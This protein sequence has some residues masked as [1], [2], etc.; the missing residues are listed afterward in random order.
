MV[1]IV[2]SRHSVLDCEHLLLLMHLCILYL[3]KKT[4]HPVLKLRILAR[5]NCS[6]QCF[7]H[8]S[9]LLNLHGIFSFI[10]RRLAG[11]SVPCDC[12]LQYIASRSPSTQFLVNT[13]DTVCQ[14]TLP[15]DI[16]ACGAQ[17]ECGFPGRPNN[18][19]ISS[20][21]YTLGV[22]IVFSCPEGLNLVGTSSIECH[23]D[24]SWIL[25]DPMSSGDI[26]VELYKSPP[27]CDSKQM[28]YSTSELRAT[29]MWT[30]APFISLQQCALYTYCVYSYYAGIR[31]WNW[32]VFFSF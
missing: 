29:I 20:S 6:L 23:T 8:Y 2:L 28:V 5:C 18:G 15:G 17:V 3:K 26:T 10:S 31:V 16:A 11:T 4:S 32:V 27:S 19:S 22:N 12:D 7:Y 30:Q 24:G 9:V 14:A 25:Y 21:N 1:C 13:S